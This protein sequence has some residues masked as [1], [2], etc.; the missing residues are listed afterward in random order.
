MVDV[1]AFSALGVEK[2]VR[3]TKNEARKLLLTLDPSK[4]FSAA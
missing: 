3:T 1:R 4:I 2:V